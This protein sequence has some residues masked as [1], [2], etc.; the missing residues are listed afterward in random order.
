MASRI[1]FLGTGGCPIVVGKQIRASGGVILEVE[2]N[3]FHINPG[4]G[5]LVRAKQFDI[6]LRENTAVLVSN[7]KLINCNDINAVLEAMTH[8]G[9]DRKGV[10]LANKTVYSGDDNVLPYL[11][12]Y[13]KSLVEK[14]LQLEANQK[15]GINDV[16]IRATAA[17]GVDPNGLGLIFFTPKFV[18]GYTG[19]TDFRSDI[20]EQY[21]EC[22]VLILNVTN[23][24]DV[25]K[26]GELCTETAIAFVSAAKP[27]LAIITHF[28]IKMVDADPISEAR[29]IQ[30]ATKVQTIAATDGL[31]ID[32]TSYSANLKTKTLN[33][34]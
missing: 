28:G 13:H 33:L 22:D 12:E 31:I 16:E 3:Q 18:L 25:K 21:K 2:D 32:P 10:L 8:A 20:A 23:P 14:S 11:T 15:V 7:N 17:K 5:S 24:K 30:K 34:Y 19:D 29:E 1:I 27:K 26:T 6:S 9:L 4:P